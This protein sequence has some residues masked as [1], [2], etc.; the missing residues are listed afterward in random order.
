MSNDTSIATQSDTVKIGVAR[1]NISPP[2]GMP[3]AGFAARGPLRALHD[4]L[5]ATGLVVADGPT[6]AALITCDLIDLDAE[7]VAEVRREIHQRMGIAEDHVSVTWSHTHYGPDPY[8][9]KANSYVMA[10]RANLI[11]LL[12]GLIEEAASDLIPAYFSVGW[13]TSYIGVNRREKREDGRIVLG[14]NPEGPI[15]RA[16]GVLRID[17]S[18]GVLLATVVNFQTHPVSQTGRTDHISA[19]YVGQMREIVEQLTGS[20]CLFLQGACGNINPVIMEQCYE[21]ARTLGTRLGCEVVRVWETLTPQPTQ[22]LQVRS[23]RIQLPRLRYGS[24]ENAEA[25]VQAL[26]D[27]LARLKASEDACEGSIKWTEKRLARARAALESWT[28]G[29]PLD[30]IETELQA[31]RLG[32]VA[33]I[34]A[35]SEIFNQIGAKVKVQSPFEPTF[36]VGYANDAL[37]YIP[38]PEVYAEGGYEVTDASRVDPEAAGIMIE[39]CLALLRDLHKG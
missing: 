39:E 21:P 38:V 1:A 27:D 36:F 25:R 26:E 13:G 20:P 3:S 32:N 16:V 37:G 9:D 6:R 14:Q 31:W 29:Q 19:D 8:R 12:A 11:H 15:D 4:P 35:P 10:Y 24:R 17:N 2:V 7:T 22:G 33:L 18:Q 28:T 23:K 5:F 30:A 34:L